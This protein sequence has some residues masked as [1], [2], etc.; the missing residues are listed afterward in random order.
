[1][2]KEFYA[3]VNPRVQFSGG[4]RF[5]L[6]EKIVLR[7]SLSSKFRRPTFNEKYWIPGGNPELHPERG[8]GGEISGEWL[9]AGNHENFWLEAVL[10]AYYQ[11]VDN[12]IQWVVRDSLVPVEYKKVKAGGFDS[13]L[14]FGIPAGQA[15]ISGSLQ[16]CFNRSVIAGT[17]DHNAQ[18]VGNQLMYVPVHMGRLAVRADYRG[19]TAGGFLTVTGSRGTVE[20]EDPSLSMPAYAL[21]DVFVGHRREIYHSE[22]RFY[23]RIDNLFN[24]QYQAIRSYPMPGRSFYIT[25]A[26][27]LHKTNPDAVIP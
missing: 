26:I 27:G 22:V 14:Y 5:R 24:V 12:W 4:L 18:I 7:S 1:M 21:Q 19:F 16:Y 3:D 20:T 10:T 8:W 17:Y 9:V 15:E 11:N 23:F 13:R 6:S 2:R 25:L